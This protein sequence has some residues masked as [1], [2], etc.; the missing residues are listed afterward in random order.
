MRGR[1]FLFTIVLAVAMNAG[2]GKKDT[3]AASSAAVSIAAL[4]DATTGVGTATTALRLFDHDINTY[5]VMASGA[6]Q[7][8]GSAGSATWTSKS[9]AACENARLFKNLFRE[10]GQADQMK[11]FLGAMDNA[12]LLTGTYDGT[13]H[14]LAVGGGTK[15]DGTAAG[16]KVKF[17][18]TK[19]ATGAITSFT[20]A[21]CFQ[22]A[23]VQDNYVSIVCAAGTCTVTA[24]GYHSFGGGNTGV[25]VNTGGARTTVTG[26]YA[27]GKWSSAKTF[28]HNGVF[29][30]SALMPPPGGGAPAATTMNMSQYAKMTEE[31]GKVTL[32]AYRT[33]TFASVTQ[34]HQMSVI[35][36]YSFGTDLSTAALG[37]GCAKAIFDWGGG[38][39][40]AQKTVCWKEDQTVD[41]SPSTATYYATVDAKTLIDVGTP[42]ASFLTAEKWDCNPPA[43]VTATTIRMSAMKPAEMQA[44]M[45]R[46]M[47]NGATQEPPCE[48]GKPN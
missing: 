8:L 2:C 41:P 19:D 47:G 38:T 21:T 25:P 20:M 24:V 3:P 28:E 22:S 17:S 15:P 35:A 44:C 36:D 6:G 14:Y 7:P 23:T 29:T 37:Q 43:G 26:T 18:A 32:D 12:G 30:G 46:D 48:G 39:S 4:P 9:R 5:A 13:D 31:S 33:G 1:L 34:Q 42:D 27:D 40:Q 45:K 10:A 16:G 11:C